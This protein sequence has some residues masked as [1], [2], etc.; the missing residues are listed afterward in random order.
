[1]EKIEDEPQEYLDDL[2][3]A[4]AHYSELVDKYPDKWVA[5][6]EAKIVAVGDSINGIRE[7][8]KRTTG[9]IRVPV[10][11]VECGSHVY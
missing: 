9:R 8:A 3:W 5:I 4:R 10:M 1:M 2:K 7:E 6:V 11:F